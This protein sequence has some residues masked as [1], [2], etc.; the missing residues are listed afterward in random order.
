MIAADSGE[1]AAHP[2]TGD[3]DLSVPPNP[4]DL[5]GFPRRTLRGGQL[6]HRLHHRDL[7]PFWFAQSAPEDPN[8]NRFDL[9]APDGA[10]Y[11][12]LEPVVALL[13]TLARRPVRLI[14]TAVVDRF[15]MTE[16]ALPQEVEAANMAV[17]AARKF[18]MTAEIHTT[19]NRPL[20]KAWAVA[21]F[22]AGFRSVLAIP[23]HDVTGR[24]RT[25]TMW[26]RTGEHAPWDWDWEPT[27][28]PVNAEVLDELATWGVRVV[29][30][31]FDVEVIPPPSA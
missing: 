10:S 28:A 14:P 4:D 5:D 17:K 3:T 6:V 26:D 9:P 11:W 1:D 16:A 13:E 12:A 8:G 18:G 24:H 15:A 19:A 20:T 25:F 30:T 27:T 21:L 2:A 29:P 22:A 7:G 23:R 31:P